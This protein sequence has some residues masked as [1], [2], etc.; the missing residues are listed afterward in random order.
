MLNFYMSYRGMPVKSIYVHKNLIGI[1]YYFISSLYNYFL[2]IIVNMFIGS[3]ILFFPCNNKEYMAIII[4][5]YRFRKCK[6][7][8]GFKIVMA[9]QF[10]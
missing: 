7:A 6:K 1:Y 4:S 10:Y 8:Y 5:P 9:L 3:G 2:G